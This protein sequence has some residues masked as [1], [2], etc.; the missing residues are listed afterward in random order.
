VKPKRNLW[1]G[2]EPT[3]KLGDI[4]P[5]QT[6]MRGFPVVSKGAP[7]RLAI[8]AAAAG[9]GPVRAQFDLP[10]FLPRGQVQDVVGPEHTWLEPNWST[11]ELR[12]TVVLE[13]LGKPLKNPRLS[14]GAHTLVYRGELSAGL[15]LEIDRAGKGRLFPTTVYR[16][17]RLVDDP[18]KAP[19]RST[20]YTV[21]G[22]AIGVYVKPGAAYELVIS[23]RGIDG[24]SSLVQL[25]YAPK[26]KQLMLHGRLKSRWQTITHPVTVPPGA[27][28]LTRYHVFRYPKKGTVWYGRFEFR[29]ADIPADGI[30]VTDQLS[31]VR[32]VL[33]RGRLN[34][35]V[36]RDRMGETSTPRCRVTVA[37]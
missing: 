18:A 1:I 9:V 2:A 14:D 37:R 34:R 5:G 10:V 4:A 30:D 6:V 16:D 24:G 32:P 15:R 28:R 25:T 11:D 33:D 13:G 7:Q 35:W 12:P 23:G 20:G 36:Y 22:S 8:E 3:A 29:R 17:P 21:G 31:G 27:D 26:G 19:A